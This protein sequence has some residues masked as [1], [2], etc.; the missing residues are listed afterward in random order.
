MDLIEP[1]VA[2]RLRFEVLQSSFTFH[3]LHLYD[4]FAE[5]VTY[6]YYKVS[7]SFL[8]RHVSSKDQT[9]HSEIF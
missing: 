9:N 4:L 2:S 7:A 6:L 1:I 5:Q 3:N 8:G